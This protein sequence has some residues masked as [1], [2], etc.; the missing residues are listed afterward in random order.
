MITLTRINAQYWKKRYMRIWQKKTFLN[1]VFSKKKGDWFID[2]GG[3]YGRLTDT[4]Y[5][6]YSHPII[7]DYSLKTLQKN[8]SIIKKQYPILN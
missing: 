3:S 7:L 5:K 2:I 8:Y 6:Q 1:K 4:Y